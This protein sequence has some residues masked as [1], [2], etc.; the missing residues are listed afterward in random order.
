VKKLFGLLVLIASVSLL[1]GPTQTVFAASIFDIFDHPDGANNP[2]GYGVRIDNLLSGTGNY[3]CMADWDSNQVAAILLG[4]M[5]AD[6]GLA[7]FQSDLKLSL[8]G[9]GSID[10][11]GDIFC[12]FDNNPGNID[13]GNAHDDFDFTDPLTGV[14]NFD[15]TYTA[16]TST[17]SG[18]PPSGT[19]DVCGAQGPGS[20]SITLDETTSA[21]QTKE[22]DTENLTGK[23]NGCFFF[24]NTD[25][26][27]LAGYPQDG[28]GFFVGRG[29]F[30]GPGTRDFLF[31]SPP[32]P[33]ITN[34]GTVSGE[35]LPIDTVSLYVI[36]LQSVS[37]W[38]IPA[39]AS[40][41]GIGIYLT[42]LRK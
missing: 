20:G 17:I 35:F 19:L 10:I 31:I 9:D 39:T 22:G 6:L 23:E 15:F 7:S 21:D 18:D 34:G 24:F 36:G 33:E 40:A 38:M 13:D 8:N 41:V 26:H 12:G 16:S 30:E 37:V 5:L 11:F 2:P 29:W 32:N 3:Q 4:D 42:K 27:R 14:Y 25:D 28:Q 1:I